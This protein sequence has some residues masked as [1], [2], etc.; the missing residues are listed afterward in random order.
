MNLSG[1]PIRKIKSLRVLQ[2]GKYFDPDQGGVET[3]T[4]DIAKGLSLH[5]IVAD[6]LCFSKSKIYSPYKGIAKVFRARTNFKFLQKSISFEYICKVRKLSSKY[7]VALLHMPNP[8]GM[9]S[10]L[11]FWRKPFVLIW[12]ADIVN[13]PILGLFLRPIEKALVRKAASI[14]SPTPAHFEG[15]YL[16]S[17]M[18]SK[19]VI[20]SYPFDLSKL[21]DAGDTSP[22]FDRLNLFLRS[23]KLILAIG[24]LV[25]YKGFDVLIAAASHLNPAA[26]I[27]I[28]GSGPLESELQQ[29]IIQSKVDDRVLMLGQTSDSD[30]N[31]LYQLA[32]VVTMPSVTRAEMY[33][34]TQVEAMSFGKPIVS[35]N[36]PMSGVPWVNKDGVSGIIVPVGDIE[37]L[38]GAINQLVI[39]TDKHKKLSDGAIALF[40]DVHDLKSSAGHYANIL[41]QAAKK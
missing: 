13:F 10:V 5:D 30:L 1:H 21:H 15:S 34:M 26:A 4:L 17:S 12:H 8:I 39:N 2:I 31:R 7:D 18:K 16:A 9:I 6:V 24:R 35:T 25:P 20:G 23:R 37:A 27:C 28:V 33:G 38:S 32:H 14:I 11:L 22:M 19:I 40:K 36:I 29:K 41:T 3:V